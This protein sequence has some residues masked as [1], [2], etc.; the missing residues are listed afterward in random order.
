MQRWEPIE[1]APKDGTLVFYYLGEDAMRYTDDLVIVARWKR[2][3][4]CI[5]DSENFPHR[6]THWLPIPP[7]P[8]A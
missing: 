4:S 5:V 3:E 2:E 8:K 1:T 7:L 6:P